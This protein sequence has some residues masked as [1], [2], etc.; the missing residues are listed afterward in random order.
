MGSKPQSN[1]LCENPKKKSTLCFGS[2]CSL[3]TYTKNVRQYSQKLSPDTMEFL[4]WLAE[5]YAKVKKTTYERYSGIGSLGKLT[6]GYTV[7]N[8]MRSS[9]MRQA[10]GMPVVCYELAILDALTAIKSR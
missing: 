7:L 1:I 10:L 8:E 9:G 6:P 3:T 4:R 5:V 2:G